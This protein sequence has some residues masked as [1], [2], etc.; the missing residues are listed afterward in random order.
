LQIPDI[1]KIEILGNQDEKIYIEFSIR[2]L[3]GLGIKPSEFIKM[4]QTT[5]SVRPAG[6]VQTENETVLLRVNSLRVSC[7]KLVEVFAMQHNIIRF[8]FL[9]S[10]FSQ[11]C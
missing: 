2:R 7:L 9:S 6:V 10:K 11:I 1:S 5:N 8:C 3:A 4:L